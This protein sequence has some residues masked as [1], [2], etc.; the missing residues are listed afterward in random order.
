MRGH[1]SLLKHLPHLEGMDK[2]IVELDELGIGG[3]CTS[4]S[5]SWN[6]ILS[7]FAFTF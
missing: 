6:L 2:G 5:Q 3:G 1:L 7:V 4:S